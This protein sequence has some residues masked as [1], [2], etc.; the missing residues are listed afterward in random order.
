MMLKPYKLSGKLYL[1]ILSVGLMA[2]ITACGGGSTQQGTRPLTR[3]SDGVSVE[4]ESSASIQQGTRPVTRNSDWT[5]VEREFNGVQMVLVPAGCFMMGSTDEEIQSIAHS[6]DQQLGSEYYESE[7]L[8][9]S[10]ETPRHQQC[11]EQQFWIDKYPVTQEQ[12]TRLGGDK[13]EENQF[14]G[15]DLPVDKITWFESRSYC[16][17]RSGRLPTEAEWEYAARGVES[18]TYPWGNEWNTDNVV[19]NVNI[20]Q[21]TINVRSIPT[22]MSWVGAV[23]MIGNV[24][25]WTSSLY[26][27]YPYDMD[28][29]RENYEPNGLYVLRGGSRSNDNLNYLRSATRN[30]HFADTS[31]LLRG[32]RC[33]MPFTK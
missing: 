18:W 19:W 22:G 16:S 32:V 28:D 15:D 20:S 10:R 5:P 13:V 26:E 31:Y 12:F 33:V 25:E 1:V 30:R 24:W 29:G 7:Y 3:N 6:I 4:P 21:D 17:S 27:L 14:M 11:F 2:L 23:H 8:F 9:F